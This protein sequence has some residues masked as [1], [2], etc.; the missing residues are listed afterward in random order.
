L[1]IWG[2]SIID[3]DGIYNLGLKIILGIC[4]FCFYLYLIGFYLFIIF[5]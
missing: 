1:I 4:I 2:L 3:G 5:I